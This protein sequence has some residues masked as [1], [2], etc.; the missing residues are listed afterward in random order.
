MKNI[1]ASNRNT[2]TN[3]T[4]HEATKHPPFPKPCMTT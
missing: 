4:V 1:N 3:A 2:A